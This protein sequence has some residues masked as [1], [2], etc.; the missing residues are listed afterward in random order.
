DTLLLTD[1]HGD[2]GPVEHGLWVFPIN[3]GPL[4][5]PTLVIESDP[6]QGPLALSP[7]DAT[8]LYTTYEGNVPVPDSTLSELATVGYANSL[9][10]GSLRSTAPYLE[11]TYVVLP[12]Q[13][14]QRNSAQYHWVT[15]PGFSPDGQ[16]LVY[17]EFSADSQSSFT[18]T[19]ALY[20]VQIHGSS[21]PPRP[22][23]VATTAAHYVELGSWWD[24]HTVT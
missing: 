8:L 23:L 11:N 12:E 2:D 18:R 5:K 10:I 3:K 9:V 15:S 14:E 22:T 19:N 21:A 20:M 6:P 4:V 13:S 17:V 24:A 1:D 16:N 7:Y